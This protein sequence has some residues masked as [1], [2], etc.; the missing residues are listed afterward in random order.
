MQIVLGVFA[1]VVIGFLLLLAYSRAV[2]WAR[3]AQKPRFVF[4]DRDTYLFLRLDRPLSAD[5]SGIMTVHALREALRLKLAG[6]GY[7]R[8]LVDASSVR[9]ASQRAFWMLVGAL[10]PALSDELIKTAVVARRRTQASKLFHESGLLNPIPSVREGER[11]LK[12]DEPRQP[13][14]MTARQFDELLAPGR[15]KAA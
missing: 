14:T 7:E 5:E 10:G 1:V 12:S 15:R 13:V 9:F 3:E 11:Y 4:E 6:V 2:E 8:L